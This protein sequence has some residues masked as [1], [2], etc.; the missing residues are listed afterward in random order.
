MD[1]IRAAGLDREV[2][3]Y[4]D[5]F[6]Y[7]NIETMRKDDLKRRKNS[8]TINPLHYE[9]CK[10]S[11]NP[12]E[13]CSNLTSLYADGEVVEQ[14]CEDRTC[15]IWLKNHPKDKA[16]RVKTLTVEEWKSKI[17]KE[18][19]AN[20]CAGCK[21]RKYKEAIHVRP[22]WPFCIIPEWLRFCNPYYDC[23]NPSCPIWSRLWWRNND[24]GSP[25]LDQEPIKL[26]RKIQHAAYALVTWMNNAISTIS[27][28]I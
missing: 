18:K 4:L 6:R 27:E 10:D 24:D 14:C 21:Y 15:P 28:E 9:M 8:D 12:C 13:G 25:L 16:K 5:S 3:D 17:S 7:A 20:P 19:P 22:Y 2:K 1:Q 23:E 11:S 26:K